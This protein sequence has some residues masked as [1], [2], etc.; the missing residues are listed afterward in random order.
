M[1]EFIRQA[2]LTDGDVRGIELLASALDWPCYVVDLQDCLTKA[3]LMEQ[4]AGTLMFPSWFG[5]N[6]DALFDCLV[7]LASAR[8]ASGCVVVLR[9]VDG[10]RQHAPEV[11]DTALAI[12]GDAAKAWQP[13]GVAMRILVDVD[14]APASAAT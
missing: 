8:R 12:F 9:H 13:R 6:W 2:V 1:N 11:L 14:G 4:V 5:H 3:A 7:D 10:L